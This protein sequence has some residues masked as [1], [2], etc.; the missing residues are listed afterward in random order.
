MFYLDKKYKEFT[1]ECNVEDINESFLNILISNK[2][3]RLSIGVQ[4]FN[5]KYIKIC[6]RK[7]TKEMAIDNITLASK[8]IKNVSIDMIYAFPFQSLP[9]AFLLHP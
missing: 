5:E 2:V 1:V 3:N 9:G 4:T 8:Y 6:N 7:H